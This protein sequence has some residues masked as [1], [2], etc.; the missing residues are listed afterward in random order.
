MPFDRGKAERWFDGIRRDLGI[1][2][3]HTDRPLSERHRE[4]LSLLRANSHRDRAG[5]LV[6]FWTQ[7][8]LAA[9]LHISTRTLRRLLDD[10]R[11]P[12]SDPRHPTTDRPPGRRLGL[13]KVEPT[14]RESPVG[15][16]V[17]AV[18]L[19]VLVEPWPA[20]PSSDDAQTRRSHRKATKKP[21]LTSDDAS[22]VA[23]H[24]KSP[25]PGSSKRV[26]PPTPTPLEV[27]GTCRVCGGGVLATSMW[28]DVHPACRQW[29]N[30]GRRYGPEVER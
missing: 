28:P 8:R 16:R 23:C 19:Y 20:G 13:V 1:P 21:P 11:E 10:L 5:R 29:P 2:A 25:T 14:R 3:G 4:L 30:T 22:S 15:G 26:V 27:V 12:G 24:N 17:F 9:K 7:D 6:S 18:N